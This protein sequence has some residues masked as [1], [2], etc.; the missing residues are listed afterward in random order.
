MSK[1]SR[2][3]SY[4]KPYRGRVALAV[5]LSFGAAALTSLSLSTLIP[6]LRTLF[7]EGG[8][9]SVQD[10][11]RDIIGF[12]S[13]DLADGIVS[14]FLHSPLAALAS[15]LGA[16]LVMTVLK[17]VLR[18]GNGYLVGTVA[19]AAG[20]DITNGL[21]AHLIRQPVL[22]FER[23]GVGTVA[24][25]FTAD[26][27][28]VVRGLKTLTGTLFREPLQFL[29]L[30]VVAIWISPLLTLA[31][32]LIFPIIGL[33]IR[34]G[35]RVAKRNARQVLAHRSR[36]LGILQESFFGIRVVQAFRAEARERERFVSENRQLFERNR[37]L[38]RVEAAISPAMEL[39][40]VLGV[41]GAL[42]LGGAMAIRGDL[43]VAL[44]V[45]FY[46]AVGA[47]YE[48]VRK[49]GSAVP[50]LQAGLAGSAR[51][52]AYLDREPEVREAPDAAPLP[53]LT[54]SIRFE[55]VTVTYGGA[56]KALRGVDLEIRAGE[57]IAF[58]GPSGAG[59]SSLVALLPRFFDPE[60]GAVLFDGTDVRT[61]TLA[62]LRSQIA[63]VPQET[64][65]LNDSLRANIAF[66]RPLATDEEI[67]EAARAAHVEEFAVRL[68][69]GYDTTVAERGAS[70]SGGQR[71]RIAIARA[72]L[73]RP[74]V[75]ILD[76]ATSNVDEESARLIR[77]AL[78]RTRE[79]RTTIVISHR[80]ETLAASDRIAVLD[81]GRL[82]AVGSHEELLEKSTAYR[83]LA[84][85]AAA[86]RAGLA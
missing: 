42:L 66:S 55:G 26:A 13:A 76:E 73:A 39:L 78:A 54:R 29:C 49:L 34:Q 10:G 86:N 12:V 20:R 9:A 4:L 68:Q 83:D 48:P 37:R 56:A 30:L 21:Y 57:Q 85:A 61:A 19:V 47:L 15:M 79:G 84:E 70:L 62:S 32:L 23:E 75:L 5:L 82:Q 44:L 43:D 27:D 2:L 60:E 17:G 74:R 35:G 63:L 77:E 72:L 36:L 67:R 71:Q 38:V 11:A 59:K 45:T 64:V 52:F 25:R 28:E 40:V 8:L 18:F 3:L 46:G 1:L 53:E 51:I 33:L 50:R 24:S 16:V 41:G 69:D 14:T 80:L 58:V 31:S 22:F 65:L 6:I 81:E 7:S